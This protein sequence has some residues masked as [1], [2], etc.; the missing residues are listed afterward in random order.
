L[1]I[2]NN[3]PFY[4][5]E[6]KNKETFREYSVALFKFIVSH[7]S[8]NKEEYNLRNNAID[9]KSKERKNARFMEA[10]RAHLNP[11]YLKMLLR[12]VSLSV[13]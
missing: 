9:S 10:L 3:I 12:P 4:C 5:I 6:N 11:K 1:N 7:L 13:I 2:L 8:S